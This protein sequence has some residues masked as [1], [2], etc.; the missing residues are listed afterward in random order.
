LAGFGGHGAGHE[1]INYAAMGASL[2]L[3]VAGIAVAAALYYWKLYPVAKIYKALR[4]VAYVLE[5]KYFFDKVYGFVFVKGTVAFARAWR[6]F[7]VHIVDGAVNAFGWGAVLW[8][9]VSG[10]FDLGA[11]DGAVNLVGRTTRGLGR[12]FRRLQTGYVQEYIVVLACGVVGIL[13][14]VLLMT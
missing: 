4:P 5:Q 2:F 12:A 6:W 7:D 10:W 1:G 14:A 3:A 9:Q 11:V 8:A 13:V